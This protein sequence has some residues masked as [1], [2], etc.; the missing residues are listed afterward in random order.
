MEK[1]IIYIYTSPSMK[2]E[3]YIKIGETTLRKDNKGN[4]LNE[5]DSVNKRIEEQYYT[6]SAFNENKYNKFEILFFENSNIKNTNDYFSDKDIHK[7]LNQYGYKYWKDNSFYIDINGNKKEKIKNT[8]EIYKVSLEIV[9]N[10]FYKIKNNEEVK[11]QDLQ[12]KRIPLILREEQLKVISETKQYFIQERKDFPK[13]TINYLWFLKMGFGKTISSYKFIKEMKFNKTIIITYIPSVED[14]WKEDIKKFEGFEDYIFISSTQKNNK[15]KKYIEKKIQEGKKV[16]FFLSFQKI[17]SENNENNE[18]YLKKIFEL[19]W[20]LLIKEE[21]HYGVHNDKS[22]EITSNIVE[23]ED[24]F[25][26]EENKFAQ[27]II[28]QENK[29]KTQNI[30]CLSGTP[31]NV[32]KNGEFSEK[33][34]SKFDYIEEQKLKEKKLAELSQED[35]EKSIYY[36]IPK[37][38]IFSFDLKETFSEYIEQGKNEFSISY[39]LKAENKE[40]IEKNKEFVKFF[41]KSLYSESEE[42]RLQQNK[43]LNDL[44]FNNKDLKEEI[45]KKELSFNIFNVHN[46]NI[47][48]T[49]M[50]HT[51]WLLPS[52]ESCYAIEKVLNE[53]EY[54]KHFK[55]LNVNKKEYGSGV[56]VVSKVKEKIENAEKACEK[57]ITL[58]LQKLGV[59]VNI[60]QWGSVLFLNEM[61][62]EQSYFQYAFRCQRAYNYPKYNDIGN[63]I[64]TKIKTE[65]YVFDFNYLRSFQMYEGFNINSSY[66]E[67]KQ[68]ETMIELT[69]YLPIL[70]FNENGKI[71]EMGIE[72]IF[73]KI[74]QSYSLLSGSEY[75]RKFQKSL[76]FNHNIKEV[77]KNNNDLLYLINDIKIEKDLKKIDNEI[78]VKEKKIINELRS[79]T[80]KTEKEKKEEEIINE[81]EKNLII[82]KIKIIYSRIPLCIYLSKTKEIDLYKIIDNFNEEQFKIIFKMTKENFKTI[83]KIT[84][85][86][87][88]EINRFVRQFH[89][90]ENNNFNILS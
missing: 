28:K 67:N 53:D 75:Q 52:I 31:F 66:N 84:N 69:N 50:E 42:Q 7:I 58:S 34:I 59:G 68:E 70:S 55:I 22:K 13:C 2:K 6:A 20:D 5:E 35:K 39:F 61:K 11:E 43:K 27:F 77:F 72:D 24:I 74:E 73:N 65:C 33:Q 40:F 81:K 48:K 14:S 41:I 64:G 17:N 18:E 86:D 26:V 25:S 90:L 87:V 10:I 19:N 8:S 83:I 4:L 37:M 51:L 45:F 9:K 12:R 3:G 23:D 16:V 60:C 44:I 62:S 21:Y 15:D 56:S 29:I 38:K 46:K 57:T 30:L 78:S 79:K 36:K 88:Q 71:I 54:F 80:N 49:Y 32:L 89:K 85:L 63:F 1:K 47:D 82:E 76:F